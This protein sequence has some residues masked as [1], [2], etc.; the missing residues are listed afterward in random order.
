[1]PS[2]AH[3]A[4]VELFRRRPTL[5]MELLDPRGERPSPSMDHAR[6]GDSSVG[7][8]LPT[9]R[10]ADLVLL[11]SDALG[12]PPRRAVVLEVQLAIDAEKRRAWWWYLVRVHTHHRCDASLVV[13]TLSPRVAAWAAKPIA[14]GHPGVSLVPLVIGPSAV[15]VVCDPAEAA[16]V[17]ELAVLSAIV[18]GRSQAGEGIA[19]AALEAAGRLDD[20][21]AALYIDVVIA[22]LHAAARN[23][24]EELMANGTYQYQ[25]DFAKRYVAQGHVEGRA[26]GKAEGRAEGKAE[27]RAEG[28]SEGKAEGRAEA[29]LTVLEAR[30]IEVT[31][32][33]RERVL[34]CTEDATLDTWL[35]RAVSAATA[36]DV[37]G[38]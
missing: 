3:E 15:P 17:P 12:G 10:A 30:G 35:T 5:A 14:L 20:E 23:I 33:L 32:S 27:G 24:L 38:K 34:A 18:H 26:E 16:A 19:R 8:I 7:D 25:S 37:L 11:F 28:K 36:R 6:V 21:R 4:I 9:E 13:V 1:M 2:F 22:S 31:T 29:I